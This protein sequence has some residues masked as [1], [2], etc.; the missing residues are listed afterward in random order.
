MIEND[1]NIIEMIIQMIN[2]IIQSYSTE[3]IKLA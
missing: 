3:S 1:S 2:N